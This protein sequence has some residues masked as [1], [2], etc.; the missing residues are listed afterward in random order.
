MYEED[1][2]KFES[3]FYEIMDYLSIC[4]GCNFSV[5]FSGT[6]IFRM[7]ICRCHFCLIVD[8]VDLITRV[9]YD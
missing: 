1:L 4:F 9:M 3:M 7:S 6:S 5:N 2:K 8:E